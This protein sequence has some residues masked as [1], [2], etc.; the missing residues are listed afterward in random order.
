MSSM[1]AK[2]I[3][4]VFPIVLLVLLAGAG[5]A[6]PTLSPPADEIDPRIQGD[7][8]RVMEIVLRQ[9]PP[10][11]RKNVMYVDQAGKTFVNRPE[12]RQNMRSFRPL[13]DGRYQASDGPVFVIPEAGPSPAAQPPQCGN[14]RTGPYRRV[15]SHPGTTA[16][17]FQMMQAQVSLGNRST[18][19]VIPDRES[20][21]VFGGGWAPG[22]TNQVDAGYIYDF[23]A[24]NWGPYFKLASERNPK[25][26][27]NIR[28][29]SGQLQE[30]LLLCARR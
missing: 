12:L 11:H 6:G 3:H 7:E 27:E 23:N 1:S 30:V 26:L 17:P 20:A 29:R 9:H 28:F 10:G 19:R 8:R 2:G 16:R 5:Q 4:L 22:F 15:R 14:Q 13:G 21:F 24:D 25:T 18:I